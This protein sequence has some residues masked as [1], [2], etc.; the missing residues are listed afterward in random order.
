MMRTAL[1]KAQFQFEEFP[2]ELAE[3]ISLLEE[4]GRLI[5]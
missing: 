5:R 3:I 4:T 2:Y 1:L